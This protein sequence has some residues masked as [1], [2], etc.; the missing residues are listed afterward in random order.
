M[1]TNFSQ[2][3]AKARKM[4]TVGFKEIPVGARFEFRGKR[5]EKMSA[6]FGRDEDRNGILF[7]PRTEVLPN[8]SHLTPGKVRSSEFRVQSSETQP[9]PPAER[10]T[11][12]TQ[13][14]LGQTTRRARP[15][16]WWLPKPED[17]FALGEHDEAVRKAE[18]L[19]YWRRPERRAG[20]L[21]REP[22]RE[23]R[24]YGTL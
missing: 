2:K 24:A 19:S 15:E 23:L 13:P 16:G 12:R 7:H 9:S 10:G 3:L 22:D 6:E 5:Y 11:T 1:K 14:Q 17:R 21:G 4:M 8:L 18:E 20:R